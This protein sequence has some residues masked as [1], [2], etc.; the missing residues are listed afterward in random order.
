MNT[1][2]NSN[3]KRTKEIVD[4]TLHAQIQI[5]FGEKW[6]HIGSTYFANLELARI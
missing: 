1:D 5:E 6:K 4:L 2:G 3:E